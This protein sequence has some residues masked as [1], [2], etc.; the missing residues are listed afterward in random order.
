MG[1]NVYITKKIPPE[2]FELLK[3]ECEIVDY[4]HLD[5]G[6]TKEELVW[7][8]KN[9]DGVISML[10]DTF[11]KEVIGSLPNLKVI[12]NYAVGFNNIDLESA[13]KR[14]I[15]VTNTPDV[16]TNATA[17]LS[18]SL[19]F[20][21]ARRVVE[22]D[23]FMRKGKWKGWNPLQCLGSDV[24]GKTLGIIGAGR[25]GS[26]M[27]RMSTGFNMRVLYTSHHPNEELEK[28]IDAKFVDLEALLKDSDYISI[29]VP[30]TNETQHMITEKELKMMKP[31]AYLI[32]TS[33]GAVIKE[34]DLVQCLKE[35]VIAGAGLDVYEFEPKVTEGLAELDN[36]VMC[37]H[38]GSA[39]KETRAKMAMTAVENLI[40]VLKGE[41]APNIVNPEV[42]S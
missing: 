13:T 28:Q 15:S 26:A 40:S 4:N 33:R 37:P 9:R 18:W 22:S 30:L 31:S 17:E 11:D 36:V 32:N 27:A 2:G 10:S 41:K 7:T 42:Y 6:L 20:A 23:K 8:L 12:S 5:R 29:H 35:E 34:A 25:I 1:F 14:K 21:V 19:L 16:L 38:I 3:K 39:T 24:S